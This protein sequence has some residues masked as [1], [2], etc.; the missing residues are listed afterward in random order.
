[1]TG[2]SSKSLYFQR[3]RYG[4]TSIVVVTFWVALP[5]P[6]GDYSYTNLNITPL[7]LE[8]GIEFLKKVM[9]RWDARG[10]M[11]VFAQLWSPSPSHVGEAFRCKRFHRNDMTPE[12]VPARCHLFLGKRLVALREGRFSRYNFRNHLEAILK[13]SCIILK[14]S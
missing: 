3:K 9:Q 5:P 2:K 10:L 6:F 8:R 1:M 7:G 12:K 14:R 4:P 13:P 11:L